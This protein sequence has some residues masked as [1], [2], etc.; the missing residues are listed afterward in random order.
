M[1]IFEHHVLRELI[2]WAGV[3]RQS[4]FATPP[5]VEHDTNIDDTNPKIQPSSDKAHRLD[6]ATTTSINEIK[7]FF[8]ST[9][10]TAEAS[11]AAAADSR[12]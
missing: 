8:K 6:A 10:M 12:T 9:K 2:T 4:T 5:G 7:L 1:R 3:F 11:E